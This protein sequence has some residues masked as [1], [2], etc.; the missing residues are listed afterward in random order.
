MRQHRDVWLKF[1]LEKTSRE[2]FN[3]FQELSDELKIHNQH[4]RVGSTKDTQGVTSQ[5]VCVRGVSPQRILD[6]VPKMNGVKIG[7][8]EYVEKPIEHGDIIKNKY[9]ITIRNI[10][11]DMSNNSS[12][13]RSPNRRM[14]IKTTNRREKGTSAVSYNLDDIKYIIESNIRDIQK[15]GF[16]NYYGPQKFNV[17]D[18]DYDT[19]LW[20]IGLNLIKKEY[21]QAIYKILTPKKS[22]VDELYSA[23]NI[24]WK[25]RIV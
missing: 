1:T 25:R 5:Y 18:D 23:K 21:K 3:V 14:K 2:T 16:L 15:N 24:L 4:L 22:D 10:N 7:N 8:F 11:T 19:P 6:C 17:S 13:S 20:K 12:K 9:E